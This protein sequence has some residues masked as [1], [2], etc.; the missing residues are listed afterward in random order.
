MSVAYELTDHPRVS[1][2]IVAG[3]MLIVGIIISAGAFYNY[4]YSCCP[5]HSKDIV[6]FGVSAVLVITGLWWL[7]S[8]SHAR[9]LL[10]ASLDGL[11]LG[12]DDGSIL[13]FSWS[14]VG[15][16]S[17][18]SV[19]ERLCLNIPIQISEQDRRKLRNKNG[20]FPR[21][22]DGYVDYMVPVLTRAK[23]LSAL[24]SIDKARRASEGIV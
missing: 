2:V 7:L 20:G 16:I 9:T 5:G 17:L 12:Q 4:F 15:E 13:Q 21:R 19:D 6:A 18:E 22:P 23:G 10:R 1:R 11:A 24:S 3:P 14:C 8:P